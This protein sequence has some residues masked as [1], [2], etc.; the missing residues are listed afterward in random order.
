MIKVAVILADGFEEL[1]ALTPFDLI[2]RANFKVDMIGLTK[3]VTGTHGITVT[4]DKMIDRDLMTYDMIIVPGGQPGA[5]NLKD[6]PLVI[7]SLKYAYAKGK[8]IGAICA[9]PIVLDYAGLLT[10][11]KYVSFPGTEDIIKS[12]TRID[13]AIVVKDGNIL[14]A[15]GAGAAFEFSLAIIDMVGGDAETI[16]ERTQYKNVIEMY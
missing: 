4:A 13:D 2:R 7:D 10:G 12:G 15:R 6:N 14:P 3:E 9:A 5:N 1:E 8:K 11:K 16:S